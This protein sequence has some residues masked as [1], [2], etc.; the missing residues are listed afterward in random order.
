MQGETYRPKALDYTR[1][2]LRLLWGPDQP[3]HKLFDH[4]NSV[5]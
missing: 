2:P 3:L 4:G 5:S 1:L